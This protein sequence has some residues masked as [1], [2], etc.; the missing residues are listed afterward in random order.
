MQYA[1][2]H[3]GT[4]LA[5]MPDLAVGLIHQDQRIGFGARYAAA[6]P[7]LVNRQCNSRCSVRPSAHNSRLSAIRHSII[8]LP[9]PAMVPL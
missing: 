6:L 7:A 1:A 4:H 3:R 9:V 2:V 5:Q 8:K